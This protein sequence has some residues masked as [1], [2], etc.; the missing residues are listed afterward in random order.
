M[1]TAL[2]LALRSD[3]FHAPSLLV[4]TAVVRVTGS[5]RLNDFGE[6]VRWLMVRDAESS[7]AEYT[8]H[9][10][11]GVLEY[12]FTARDGIPFPAF[13]TASEEF[14]ELRVEAEWEND[15]Q[16][17]RGRVVLE[18]GRPIDHQSAPLADRSLG[19][20]VEIGL[21]GEL[22]FAMACAKRGEAWL[23]YCVDGSRHAYF[24][25]DAALR[26]ADD[27]GARWT[28]RIASDRSEPLDEPV[29]D[30]LLAALEDIAFR[31]AGDWLWFEEA[32]ASE[33]ALERRRY[34]DHGWPVKGANLK[35]ERL[36]TLGPRRQFDS[37]APEAQPLLGRLRSAWTSL[38]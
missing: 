11:E 26:F 21:R 36:L 8:E 24:A 16:G 12:R 27:A 3:P 33:T 22:E 2:Q 20:A 18:N 17:V 35:A 34:A 25:A 7:R 9:H 15:V 13:A 23:G 14:P 37:L 10:R 30:A 19:V 38:R 6:R 5:G 1:A 32:A 4:L 28:R 31:F 29:D